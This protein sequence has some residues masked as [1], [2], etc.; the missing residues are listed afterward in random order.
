M[1]PLKGNKS[2]GT[3]CSFFHPW[4]P[5]ADRPQTPISKGIQ[6]EG[7][8]QGKHEFEP[9]EGSPKL[10]IRQG[11]TSSEWIKDVHFWRQT[12]E[13]YEPPE[14]H[15]TLHVIQNERDSDKTACLKECCSNIAWKGTQ[16]I[17]Q[18]RRRTYKDDKDAGDHTIFRPRV[19]FKRAEENLWHRS[20]FTEK[21]I[22]ANTLLRCF[23][24]RSPTAEERQPRR[25]TQEVHSTHTANGIIKVSQD[26]EICVRVEHVRR[27]DTGRELARI[28]FGTAMRRHGLLPHLDTTKKP[29]LTRDGV[30]I[31]GCSGDTRN[32][33]RDR[34]PEW[35]QPYTEG[36]VVLTEST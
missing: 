20:P 19:F 3:E 35:L 17:F 15:P 2:K 1:Y 32:A 30:S 7:K 33:G 5:S 28:V 12:L 14:K 9:S 11:L 34:M 24:R 23:G 13:D 36:L 25:P 18:N 6:V 31:E 16:S 10:Q 22:T 27:R 26:A 29:R 8:G 21:V 4:N